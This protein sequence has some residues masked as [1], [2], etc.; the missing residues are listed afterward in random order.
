MKIYYVTTNKLKAAEANAALNAFKAKSGADVQLPRYDMRL[1]EILDAEI[2]TTVRAKALKAY[3]H[4]A[5]PCVVEHSGLFMDALPGLLG[6]VGGFV[7]RA[8]E[9]RMCGF[10]RDGD[11]RGAVAR[12]IVGYC[13]GR[14]VRLYHGEARGQIADKARGEYRLNWDP[15][16]IPDGSD[17]TYGEMGLEKKGATSPAMIAWAAFLEE[18]CIDQQPGRRS[19]EA[20]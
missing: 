16:F 15:I 19:S 12:S 8:I 17:Q 13:D 11:S 3:E 2:D 9:D 10:L 14:H 5:V 4:L 20:L 1:E 7:W 18:L 6:G